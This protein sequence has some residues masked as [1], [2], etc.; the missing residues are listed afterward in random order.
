MR[1]VLLA[2]VILKIK[3]KL[4]HKM[5]VEVCKI[6]WLFFSPF[7]LQSTLIVVSLFVS[8]WL[9]LRWDT[10]NVKWSALGP[11]FLHRGTG[12]ALLRFTSSITLAL[13]F[14]WMSSSSSQC[15]ECDCAMSTPRCHDYMLRLMR[16][17][18][19]A[20]RKAPRCPLSVSFLL[21]CHISTSRPVFLQW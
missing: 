4:A 16:Q 21:R 20:S 5:A 3:K 13:Y 6:W 7:M 9:F 14:S 2:E 8:L 1:D 11:F 12:K 10:A 17:T 18:A 19:S 15:S